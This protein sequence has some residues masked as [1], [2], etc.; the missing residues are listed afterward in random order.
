[1]TDDPSAGWEAVAGQFAA[2]RSS[3]GSDIVRRWSVHLPAGGAILDIGC[4][5]GVS[6]ARTLTEQGFELYGIDASPTLL[7]AFRRNIPDARAA[8]EPVESSRFFDRRFDGVVAIGLLFLL[9]GD[10]QRMVIRRVGH[11]LRAGGRFLFTAPTQRCAWTD[12]L[13]GRSSLSLGEEEYD[14][15][16]IEAGLQRVGVYEDEGGNYYYDAVAR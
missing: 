12:S 6:I 1:M 11:A 16:L 3:V 2:I 10:R 13:T 5:T 15:L 9:A 14:H 7:E 4:G 8:C